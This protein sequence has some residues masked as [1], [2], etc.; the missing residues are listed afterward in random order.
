MSVQIA[1]QAEEPAAAR[2]IRTDAMPEPASAA[3]AVSV[4]VPCSGEPGSASVADEGAVLS[5]RPVKI[6]EVVERPAPSVAI[7]RAS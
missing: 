3:V 5:I 2:S 6:A 1:D 4:A 7:A